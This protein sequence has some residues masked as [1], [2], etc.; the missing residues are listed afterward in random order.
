MYTCRKSYK[1]IAFAHRQHRH[2]GH[3]SLVHGHNWTFTFEF[4]SRELDAL[5]FVFDFGKMAF[6]RDE[7]VRRFDHAFVFDRDDSESRGL[8]ALRPGLF[9]A[10]EVDSSSC[11]GL[12]K[13]LHDLFDP[14]MRRMTG[15]R[16]WVCSVQV[17]ED[18]RNSATYRPD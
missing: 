16:V 18:R 13:Y 5:G 15:G 4:A 11:E 10:L 8:V 6:I 1:D 9:K 17:E 2:E 7:I 14:Q 3:C 12:A